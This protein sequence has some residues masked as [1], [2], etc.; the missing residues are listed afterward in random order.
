M[1]KSSRG[2]AGEVPRA[3]AVLPRRGSRSG[4]RVGT[5]FADPPRSPLRSIGRSSIRAAGENLPLL[6]PGGAG[7]GFGLYVFIDK[8]RIGVGHLSACSLF[9]GIGV[10]LLVGGSAGTVIDMSPDDDEVGTVPVE[11]LL[12]PATPEPWSESSPVST[13][14]LDTAAPPRNERSPTLSVRTTHAESLGRSELVKARIGVPNVSPE[15]ASPAQVATE[16]SVRATV[17]SSAAEQSSVSSAPSSQPDPLDQM[18]RELEM[19]QRERG[20]NESR[21]HK[22]TARRPATSDVAAGP[23]PTPER[24]S[25]V[26]GRSTPT[27]S[28]PGSIPPTPEPSLR[29]PVTDSA[30]RPG[31]R[32]ARLSIDPITPSREPLAK[33]LGR[34][35]DPCVGCGRP[36]PEES[37]ILCGSCGLM[38]CPECEQ[39]AVSEGSGNLCPT[40][41]M[42][43]RESS[44]EA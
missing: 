14:A 44:R 43:L 26:D 9:V 28:G 24:R 34:R 19:L 25:T 17:P 39:R 10:I 37:S 33:V 32:D 1:A 40:C 29:T 3:P 12:A 22:E 6:F 41:A 16:G 20:G 8:V 7:L 35:A 4:S 11:S 27:A 5:P 42:L 30:D 21:T 36:L 2:A 31:S 15:P 38:L 23:N 13:K 18:L